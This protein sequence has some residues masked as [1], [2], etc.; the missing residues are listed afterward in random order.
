MVAKKHSEVQCVYMHHC[1]EKK[2]SPCGRVKL[3]ECFMTLDMYDRLY[4][5][6]FLK[7]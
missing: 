5:S 1:L 7:S 2:I 6:F 3:Q 4:S